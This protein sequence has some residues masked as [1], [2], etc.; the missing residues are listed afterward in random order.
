MG[1]VTPMPFNGVVSGLGQV[2][3][4][5]CDLP[6]PIGD[7]PQEAFLGQIILGCNDEQDSLSFTFISILVTHVTRISPKD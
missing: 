5:E 6:K 7:D 4:D 1:T 3:Q 2:P